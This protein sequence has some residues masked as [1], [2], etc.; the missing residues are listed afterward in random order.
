M[1]KVIIKNKYKPRAIRFL[2][3]YEHNNWHIK[4]YT[5]SVKQKFQ[6]TVVIENVMKKLGDWLPEPT[7]CT[8][9][10]YK[11]AILIIHEGREGIFTLLNWWIDDNMIQNQVWFSA[12]NKPFE[13]QEFSNKGMI[14]CVWELAV[15]WFER[16]AW[17][18]N[19]LKKP[20]SPDIEKYLSQHLNKD[21]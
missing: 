1:E 8:F 14:V 20:K 4:V 6:N 10:N 13:F 2:E 7:N 11:I 16:N 21:I 5:I 18:K 19:V 3:I 15:I 9:T 12:H 17:V